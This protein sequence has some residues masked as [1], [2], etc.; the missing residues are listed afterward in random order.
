MMI[1]T[2][3]HEEHELGCDGPCGTRITKGMT[4][5]V[6]EDNYAYCGE[7]MAEDLL[8]ELGS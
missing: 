8:D 1:G 5:Y 4:Y 2:V 6:C 7:C 3:I